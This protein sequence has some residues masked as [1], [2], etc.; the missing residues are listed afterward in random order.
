[1]K[2]ALAAMVTVFIANPQ[3][4]ALV[5]YLLESVKSEDLC[6]PNR[7]IINVNNIIMIKINLHPIPK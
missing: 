2:Y 5:A 7:I 3:L 1:M 4:M 6:G